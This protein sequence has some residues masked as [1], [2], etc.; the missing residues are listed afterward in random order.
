MHFVHKFKNSLIF[1][2]I[3]HDEKVKEVLFKSGRRINIHYETTTPEPYVFT[4]SVEYTKAPFHLIHSLKNLENLR[5]EA[6]MKS[7]SIRR[8]R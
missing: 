1:L 4:I 7:R 8:C 2:P 6:L 3:S 5:Y